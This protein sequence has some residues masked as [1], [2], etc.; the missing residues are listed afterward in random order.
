MRKLDYY[1]YT[2]SPRTNK[3][4]PCLNGVFHNNGFK[5]ASDSHIFVAVKESYPDDLEGKIVSKKG[6]YIEGKYPNYDLIRPKKK[7]LKESYI[8]VD[9]EEMFATPGEYKVDDKVIETVDIV[10]CRFNKKLFDKL[11]AAMDRIGA[12]RVYVNRNP[13]K[14]CF[15]EGESGW[16]MLMPIVKM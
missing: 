12:S 14:P 9:R 13:H 10:L 8:A 2:A 6:E 4:R 15:A 3:L 16:A 1:K 5:V 11:S 7:A